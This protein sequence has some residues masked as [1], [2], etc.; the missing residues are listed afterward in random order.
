MTYNQTL[1]FESDKAAYDEETGNYGAKR[2]D[3]RYPRADVRWRATGE[4]SSDTKFEYREFIS[5]K[6]QRPIP[7]KMCKWKGALFK[8]I[9]GSYKKVEQGR[10]RKWHSVRFMEVKNGL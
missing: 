10:G 6:S 8:P 4:L 2:Y 1:W 7:M 9:A 5:V 3:I